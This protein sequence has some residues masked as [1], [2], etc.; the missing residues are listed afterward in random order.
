MLFK[1]KVF[2]SYSWESKEHNEWVYR[3][4][5]MLEN[6][7]ISVEIDKN[8]KNGEDINK[9]I[10]SIKEND[11]IL[12]VLTPT[13]TKKANNLEGGVGRETQI[14][15]YIDKNKIIPILKDGD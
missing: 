1:K 3:L 8:L 6:D 13:Y 14:L 4:S 5:E 9:F 2:I 12:V 7:G 10:N 15:T 11:I